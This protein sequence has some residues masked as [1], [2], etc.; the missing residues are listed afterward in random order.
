MNFT[1][2]VKNM[3]HG[4]E[5]TRPGLPGYVYRSI[6]NQLIF[7]TG[8]YVGI[9]NQLVSVDG[10]DQNPDWY[11][12][13]DWEVY[14]PKKEQEQGTL[15]QRVGHFDFSKWIKD[16]W[17]ITCTYCKQKYNGQ[18]DCSGFPCYR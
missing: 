5:I 7:T 6:D 13:D 11:D 10:I 18:K 15:G 14:N 8:P 2:A 9:D 12:H 17:D 1:E 16:S 3:E 4:D